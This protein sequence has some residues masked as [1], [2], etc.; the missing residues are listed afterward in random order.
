[1]ETHDKYMFRCLQLAALGL[2]YVRPNPLVGAI[3]LYNDTIIGE[4]YHEYFGGP[5][6]EVNCLNSVAEKNKKL[7]SSST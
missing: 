5:H 7:I 1:M 4:G 6:A 3:L 2:G